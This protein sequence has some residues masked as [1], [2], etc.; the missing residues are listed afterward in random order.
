MTISSLAPAGGPAAGGSTVVI[1][2]MC[3]E[4][5][6]GVA[7][8]TFGGSNAAGYHV[9]SDTQ[10]TAV[11]PAHVAGVVDV[12]VVASP[13]GYSSGCCVKFTFDPC[14]AAGLTP[15]TASPQPA[16]TQIKF[17]ATSSTCLNPEYLFF[18]KTPGGAWKPVQG[19]GGQTWLWSTK[20]FAPGLYMV[21]VWAREV[22]SGVRYEAFQL[23]DY[24]LTP[25]APCTGAG[26]TSDLAS[27]Q[28][29]DFKVTFTATATGCLNPEYLYYLKLPSGSWTL[30]RGYGISTWAWDTSRVA[31]IGHFLV[32]VWVRDRGSRASYQTFQLVSFTL[33]NR[34]CTGPGFTSDKFS[35]QQHGVVITFTA[36]AASCA[37]P[38]YL[39]YLRT[40][41]PGS[42]GTWAVVQGYGGKT[43][44][45]N[46]AGVPTIGVYTVDVWV[47]AI[48]SGVARQA[49]YAN[50][51]WL[52]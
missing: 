17:T 50:T 46:T 38:E 21:D 23:I 9:D 15:D 34:V 44:V 40:P 45:W 16:D 52:M 49:S 33:T 3:F 35:P 11:T 12:T 1:T 51:F 14:A 4:G 32:D 27:P 25:S 8:V 37:R 41:G 47:R 26:L 5:S 43:W 20:G 29:V 30:A 2:G 48:G 24:T 13:P 6:Q 18:L 36:S 42:T 10:I 28:Q 22:G 31:S 19:Y 7:A 39:F